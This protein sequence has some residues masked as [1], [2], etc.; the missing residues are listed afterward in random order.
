MVPYNNNRRTPK[1]N[2]VFMIGYAWP[3]IIAILSV[4]AVAGLAA[5]APPAGNLVTNGWLRGGIYAFGFGLYNGVADNVPDKYWRRIRRTGCGACMAYLS[6]KPAAYFGSKARKS[7]WRRR[8]TAAWRKW[9][10][11]VNAYQ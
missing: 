10:N 6:R 9:L 3:I 4:P 7:N 11:V 5:P 2:V 8:R 1:V